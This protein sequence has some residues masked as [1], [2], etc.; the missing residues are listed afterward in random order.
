MKLQFIIT[1]EFMIKF[2]FIYKTKHGQKF[3]KSVA[4]FVGYYI[5]FLKNVFKNKN[6]N[7]NL[8]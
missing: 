7:F 2:I 3:I 8:I 5:M 6:L 4:F 1:Y